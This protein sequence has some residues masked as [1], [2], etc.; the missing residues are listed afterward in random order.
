MHTHKLQDGQ[1]SSAIWCTTLPCAGCQRVLTHLLR[2]L[3][4]QKQFP[5]CNPSKS[6]ATHLLVWAWWWLCL[7]L[8]G[9]NG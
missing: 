6:K 3:D 9:S 4:Y 8:Q 7:I 5:R 1:S 2:H